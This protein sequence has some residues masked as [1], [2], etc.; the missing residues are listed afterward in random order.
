M[1]LCSIFSGLQCR[2]ALHCISD[3]QRLLGRAFAERS[4]V[5][6]VRLGQLHRNLLSGDHE[7][8][9]TNHSVS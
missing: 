3:A 6:S 5:S 9:K 1:R 8:I 4:H 2:W 7:G